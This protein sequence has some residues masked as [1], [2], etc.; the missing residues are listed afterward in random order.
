MCTANI[1]MSVIAPFVAIFVVNE[2]CLRCWVATWDAC[3]AGG[4]FDITYDASHGKGDLVFQ[5]VTHDG[6]CG[7]GID[8]Y[9]S[10][11]MHC[12]RSVFDAV[13]KL[14]MIKLVSTSHTMI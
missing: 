7:Y 8:K 1:I 6:I 4:N 12:A 3:S 9:S 14:V 10:S 11:D 2:S 5:V 13:G